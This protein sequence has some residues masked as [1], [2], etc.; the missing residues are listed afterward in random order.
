MTVWDFVWC[1]YV[2]R[3]RVFGGKP[4]RP[5]ACGTHLHSVCHV[6]AGE[7]LMHCRALHEEVPWCRQTLCESGVTEKKASFSVSRTSQICC[8][9]WVWLVGRNGPNSKMLCSYMGGAA[10]STVA[11]QQEGPGFGSP[12]GQ[13]FFCVGFACSPCGCFGSLRVLWL[14]PT[15]WQYAFRG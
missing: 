11:S 1:C 14:S 5:V 13:R 3:Q 6:H 2:H 4:Q 7:G 10:V 9:M 12:G 8:Q 15:V